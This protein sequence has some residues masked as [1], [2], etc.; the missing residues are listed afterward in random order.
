MRPFFV[1]ILTRK[2]CVFLRRRVFGWNVRLP[3]MVSYAK[4]STGRS[5]TKLQY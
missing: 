1:A 2:P 3:F 5:R 4:D